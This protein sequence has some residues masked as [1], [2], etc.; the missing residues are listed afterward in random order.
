[1]IVLAIVRSAAGAAAVLPPLAAGLVLPA[2]FAAVERR[3]RAP[4]VPSGTLTAP[5]R[6]PAL[7]AGVALPAGLGALLFLGT[8]YLQRA[9]GFDPLRTGLAYLALTL[10]VVVAS[11]AAA[12]LT[13][14]WGRRAV[15][16]LGLLVQAGGLLL[17]AR[18]PAGGGFVA[19]VLPAFLLVGA[20]APL[21]F[22]PVTAAIMGGAGDASG[23][24]SGVFNTAQQL[25]NAL[26]LAVLAT[27]VATRAEALAGD[28][29]SRTDALTGGLHAGFLAGA[30]LL[31]AACLPAL[32]LAPR[33]PQKRVMASSAATRSSI[34]ARSRS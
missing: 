14:R 7:L 32:R 3:A 9:L 19:D 17:L 33:A 13:D 27:L 8:L 18:A 11:P 10:P 28:G 1:M 6:P 30:V 16:V 20:G 22:V 4:L 24:V 5:G 31:A 21:A 23:L 12:R 34:S 15:A 2:G 25:G 29:L 26:A